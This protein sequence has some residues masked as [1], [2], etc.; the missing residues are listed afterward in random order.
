M[1]ALG[2]AIARAPAAVVMIVLGVAL[3]IFGI[4]QGIRARKNNPDG[5][6]GNGGNSLR[7]RK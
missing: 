6:Q 4:V 3:V 7:R 2:D 5:Q 1:A